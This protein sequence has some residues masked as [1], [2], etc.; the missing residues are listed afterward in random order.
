[1]F[2][3]FF[4]ALSTFLLSYETL[5]SQDCGTIIKHIDLDGEETVWNS[6]INKE[7]NIYACGSIARSGGQNAS[8]L[9]KTD[10]L[11]NVLWS[12][13]IP[14][15]GQ[16]LFR[17]VYPTSDSGVISVGISNTYPANPRFASM[18]VKWDKNGIRQWSRSLNSNSANGDWGLGILQ[19]GDGG[20]LITGNLNSAGF[21]A[22][23]YLLK[24]S[25][26]GIFEWAKSYAYFEGLEFQGAIEG[27]DGYIISG[28][29]LFNSNTS[30]RPLIIKVNKTN[31]N[32]QLIKSFTLPGNVVAS[33]ELKVRP[34]GGYFF[35]GMDLNY[36]FGFNG[37][38]RQVVIYLNAGL[39]F[40][41]AVRISQGPLKNQS[42]VNLIPLADGGFISSIGGSKE[43][44]DAHFYRVNINGEI[45]WKRK[46]GGLG[47]QQLTSSSFL[48]DSSVV[49]VG[50]TSKNSLVSKDILWV[51]TKLG[52]N[53]ASCGMQESDAV[54]E[55]I[56][57]SNL[58]FNFGSVNNLSSNLWVV[59][60]PAIQEDGHSE[61][62]NCQP[63]C[64]VPTC[65]VVVKNFDIG[66]EE[67][68]W[69]T[70]TSPDN[71]VY[72]AG[73][74]IRT[75]GV[76]ASFVLKTDS[77][78]VPIWSRAIPGSGDQVFYKVLAT[79][80]SGIL[81][82]G[83]SRTYP[84]SVAGSAIVVKWDKNGTRK[85]SR[86]Y[87]TNAPNLDRILGIT[88]T[89]DGGYLLVGTQ[90]A[91]GY[92][93]NGLVIKIDINGNAQWIKHYPYLEGADI[94][95]VLEVEDGY[96]MSGNY[97]FN[98]NTTYGVFVMKISK[99]DGGILQTNSW[100]MPDNSIIYHSRLHKTNSGYYLACTQLVAQ[101]PNYFNNV[102]QIVL[103]LDNSLNL[104]RTTR[105]NHN[106]L[107]NGLVADILPMPDGSY[108]GAAGGDN[109]SD[110]ADIYKVSPQGDILWK[111]RI[112]GLGMQ[113]LWTST[114]MEDS[115][116]VFVGTS[117]STGSKDILWLKLPIGKSIQGCE[118]QESDA[119]SSLI[120]VSTSNFSFS[121][122]VNGNLGNW[123]TI[124]PAIE[125]DNYLTTYSC[126]FVCDSNDPLPLR[127]ITIKG[128]SGISNNI[129]I[130]FETAN[131][132]SVDALAIERSYNGNLFNQIGLIE[133]K[134]KIFN[135][136]EFLDDDLSKTFKSVFYRIKAI[137]KDGKLSYSQVIK[138]DLANSEGYG[139]KLYPNP[140]KGNFQI[141]YV[142]ATEQKKAVITIMN[143][144]GKQITQ[145]K[146]DISK[147]INVISVNKSKSITPGLYYIKFNGQSGTETK[148][149]LIQ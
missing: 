48:A 115:S 86:S 13:V 63:D 1:M 60:N 133:P 19:T 85:W 79:K 6:A 7:G 39:D 69:S 90:N 117:S 43:N 116:I 34:N 124:N 118:V 112:V 22:S 75:G 62:Y 87:R 35:N 72:L 94:L 61:T 147:G 77:A 135:S 98:T 89:T 107:K 130:K 109:A 47:G 30:Y 103:H 123:L 82:A 132:V 56:S 74:A 127:F 29:Y 12:R 49:F 54:A 18:V 134:G 137:D 91:A 104:V 40:E 24:V 51:R 95:S 80:D 46:I 21:Q 41:K 146:I 3:T 11:G 142:S 143:I 70:S 17:R 125:S 106:V 20:F 144:D 93:A 81:A 27:S 10:T 128:Q 76:Q 8:F 52:S 99:N 101:L 78:G 5:L 122:P 25:A 53:S 145:Y 14:G 100:K 108:V 149:I 121:Q 66:G 31:G 84:N 57:I 65:G 110:D 102:R 73:G 58:N 16:Q 33:G 71:Y 15:T 96:L 4:L 26:Q 105:I 44:D 120:S 88:E 126:G 97:L 131:E 114:P 140:S 50:N 55:L 83:L 136:Y 28:E 119:V 64:K 9:V 138:M 45:T 59:I 42:L 37:D 68:V 92:A 32:V 129:N 67:R 111:T 23:A 36:S 2:K 113:N 141:Q 139:L 38:F 148:K